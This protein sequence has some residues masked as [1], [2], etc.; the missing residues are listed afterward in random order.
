MLLKKPR[1]CLGCGKENITHAGEYLCRDCV[2]LLNEGKAFRKL[3]EDAE[4]MKDVIDVAVPVN[5]EKPYFE[6]YDNGFGDKETVGDV[7][8]KL[9]IELLEYKERYEG[10]FYPS[11]EKD[12]YYNVYTKFEFNENVE[13]AWASKGK[14]KKKRA[15]LL[16]KLLVE[17][18]KAVNSAYDKGLKKGKSALL[19]LAAGEISSKQLDGLK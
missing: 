3:K 5:W 14:M 4:E 2:G 17:I 8:R 9:A 10:A 19:Q 11:S 6:N 16:N 1:R 12:I 7:L 13:W 18:R 15:V